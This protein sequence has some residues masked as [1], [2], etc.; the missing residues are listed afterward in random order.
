MAWK[1]TRS[2]SMTDKGR[3]PLEE[4][5]VAKRRTGTRT[6]RGWH[7]TQN[8]R[9][10]RHNTGSVGSMYP[11]GALAVDGVRRIHPTS[12]LNGPNFHSL[13]GAQSGA[14]PSWFNRQLGVFFLKS[15]FLGLTFE[16][17][18]MRGACGRVRD[19]GT[20]GAWGGGR[21]ARDVWDVVHV[22]DVGG[23]GGAEEK[24]GT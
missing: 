1:L 15:P 14:F 2:R 24:C 20:W 16:C 8:V 9:A 17:P 23:T 3:A 5:Q 18:G 13:K 11:N 22:R 21:D 6:S 19:V 4:W 7:A 10:I 12:S